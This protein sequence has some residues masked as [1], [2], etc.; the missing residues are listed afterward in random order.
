MN[1]ET[2]ERDC[3]GVDLSTRRAQDVPVSARRYI[4]APDKPSGDA[5][6]TQSAQHRRAF[7][8]EERDIFSNVTDEPEVSESGQMDDEDGSGGAGTAD[9]LP[10]E[11][12]I[13]KEEKE[14]RTESIGEANFTNEGDGG[15]RCI[16]TAVNMP[17]H[18]SQ[19][20]LYPAGYTQH[21]TRPSAPHV[22]KLI[23][24]VLKRIVIVSGSS[25]TAAILS[26]PSN[27]S[28]S[29]SLSSSPFAFCTR[30][31]SRF[32]VVAIVDIAMVGGME[33]EFA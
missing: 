21:P 12:C 1:I 29:P 14:M 15:G 32:F 8:L 19:S 28:Q 20:L 25:E 13:W 5:G 10:R 30:S 18:H 17:T 31:Y 22:D 6:D 2:R 3:V 4:L 23:V 16:D 9:S 24:K 11:T 27:L 26:L 7:V 33:I